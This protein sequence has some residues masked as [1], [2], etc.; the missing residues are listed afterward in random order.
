MKV[1][2]TLAGNIYKPTDI[3]EAL[4]YS[5]TAARHLGKRVRIVLDSKAVYPVLHGVNG[6]NVNGNNFTFNT[7]QGIIV[8]RL[9]YQGSNGE[10]V[11]VVCPTIQLLQKI[12][13]SGISLLIVV[14][15]MDANACQDIFH[16][17][18]LNSAMDIQTGA[19]LSGIGQPVVGIMR[20]VGYLKDYS[21]RM[22]VHLTSV[23]VYSGEIADVANTLK[24]QGIVADYEEVLKY[25]LYRGLSF[26]EACVVAKAFSQKSLL[27]MRGNPNFGIYWNNINNPKWE[28]NP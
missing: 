16:W 9:Q 22:N 23:P 3:E 2:Y 10:I 6:L 12:Q 13:D 11:V 19:S 15:E 4:M 5:E 14:P 18:D 20:A 1:V 21:Q 8:T 17:L 28:Q 27:K 26:D 25:C 24:K 7:I